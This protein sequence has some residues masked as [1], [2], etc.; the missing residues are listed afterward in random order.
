M[1][2]LSTG[3]LSSYASAQAN[4]AVSPE[5]AGEAAAFFIREFSSKFPEWLGANVMNSASYN[6]IDGEKIAYEYIVENGNENVGF[7]VISATKELSPLLECSGGEAPSSYIRK[8]MEKCVE[9]GLTTCDSETTPMILYWGAL[10]YSI[11]FDDMKYGG[12]AV[13]LPTGRIME[14]PEYVKLLIDSEQAKSQWIELESLI[15]GIG[16]IG[17]RDAWVTIPGVPAY[18]QG[19]DYRHGDAGNNPNA[20]YPSCAGAGDDPWDA[21]DG[22]SCIAGAMVHGYWGN[23]DYSSLTIGEDALIDENHHYMGT[24]DEGSTWP[25]DI[26]DGIA[27]VFDA[28]GHNDTFS[29]YNTS[30]T[31]WGDVTTFVDNNNPTVLSFLG[32]SYTGHSATLVGYIDREAYDYITVHST[33]DTYET[34]ISWGDW[35]I[36]NMT[37]VFEE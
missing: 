35:T 13:H 24:D 28:Y 18:Y 6:S 8:A 19:G 33:W 20:S 14:V 5:Q 15:N 31:N 17:A 23:N 12:E 16:K 3:A 7:L 37:K 21:W 32:G 10:T 34:L 2:L 29:V 1:M 30:G 26:D 36:C 4:N 9:E 27:A 25:W 22:C 11:Q